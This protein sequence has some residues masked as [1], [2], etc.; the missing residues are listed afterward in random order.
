MSGRSINC[1]SPA[2]N[3]CTHGELCWFNNVA[4]YAR[5]HQ[6]GA[7][8]RQYRIK[9][10]RGQI[11]L[12]WDQGST[13]L[14]WT[15]AWVLGPF[16]DP[17]HRPHV[18]TSPWTDTTWFFWPAH[19]K[20]WT[21]LASTVSTFCTFTFWGIRNKMPRGQLLALQYGSYFFIYWSTT[22]KNIMKEIL[23]AQQTSK[24]QDIN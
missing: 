23:T 17:A 5:Q 7:R 1:C 13:Q 3:F 18:G 24:N 2:A 19:W 16:A 6:N 10:G 4:L 14:D 20:D 15:S 9:T 11:G 8:L 21:P 22:N 12:L